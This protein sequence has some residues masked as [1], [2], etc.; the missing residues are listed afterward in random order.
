MGNGTPNG[1][2]RSFFDAAMLMETDDCIIWPYSKLE[3]G[4]GHLRRDDGKT[5]LVHR[6]AC[7]IEHGPAPEGKPLATHGPCHNPSCFNR[8]HVG[9]GS[10]KDNAADRRRD[11]TSPIGR[12][13]PAAK[14]SESDVQEIRQRY[15][16]G[17]VTHEK[18][19]AEYGVCRVSV[20]NVLRRKTWNH[21]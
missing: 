17:G 18:L 21:L 14:L 6:L 3:N 16:A 2:A 11:G 15:A 9:W 12:A 4:H 19:A 5:S 1:A 20:T 8:R 13:N 10:H 7:E